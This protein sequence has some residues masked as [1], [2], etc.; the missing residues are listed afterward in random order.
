M[1][2]RQLNIPTHGIIKGLYDGKQD[3]EQM[4]QFEAVLTGSKITSSGYSQMVFIIS[5]YLIIHH[6]FIYSV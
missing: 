6:G 2:S 3:I 4:N 1:V 5:V